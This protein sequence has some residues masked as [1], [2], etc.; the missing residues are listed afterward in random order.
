M[1]EIIPAI[2]VKDFGEL[3]EKIKRVE[4]YFSF[5]QLDVM[6]DRF[7]PNE[8]F[9]DV[10]KIK[11]IKTS[12]Q[13]E[14]HLMAEKPEEQIYSWSILKPKRFIFH[15]EAV[16]QTMSQLEIKAL[17]QKIKNYGMQAGM[18]VNPET[19]LNEIEE[20]VRDLD[21]VLLM[22]VNPGFG[23][24]EFIEATLPRIRALRQFWSN[25]KIE[26]DGGIKVGIAKRCAEA[27]ADILVVGSA[28]LEAQNLEN[29][30][31]VLKADI[32]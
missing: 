25:G 31:K 8:T 23:G 27:G 6:D 12:L 22:S 9:R 29:T 26:V 24:Q 15:Y 17:I 16:S 10:Q 5:V 13:W 19:S 28:I 18:A 14:I 11:E 1:V 32:K 20:F 7:V 3:E 2:I 21:L 30:I 4:P